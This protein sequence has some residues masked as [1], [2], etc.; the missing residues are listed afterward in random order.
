MKKVILSEKQIKRLMDKLIINEQVSSILPDNSKRIG[1]VNENGKYKIC[2]FFVV[3]EGDRW[4]LETEEKGREKFEIPKLSD[5]KGTISMLNGEPKL[6]LD[7]LVINGFKAGNYVGLESTESECWKYVTAPQKT[8]FIYVDPDYRSLVGDK[9]KGTE[10]MK[11][12]GEIPVFCGLDYH[13]DAT[14]P[15]RFSVGDLID[16]KE[17]QVI[18]MRETYTQNFK[19]KF[20]PGLGGKAIGGDVDPTK[21]DETPIEN[22]IVLT[23][24]KGLN[25]AFNFDQITLNDEGNKNLQ[26]LINYAKQNYQGISANVPVICSASID[27]DPN[28][29]V[30]GNMRRS[31]YNL[32]LSKRRA[33]AIAN[34]LTTQ[35][36]IDTLKFIPQGIGET[37]KFDTGKKW[38]EVKDKNQTVGNRKLIIQLPKLQK[39]IQQQK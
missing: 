28:Q 26:D 14:D 13:N 16:E 2:D 19:F 39:T 7:P 10:E 33:N 12:Y 27:A 11:S 31:D 21:P 38:P 20:M 37:D 8:W 9:M 5:I 30:K 36:G 35:I 22:P 34:M 6:K 18:Q 4:F 3:K 25:D 1:S 24:E 29:M 17:G 15:T 23:F 32:Q